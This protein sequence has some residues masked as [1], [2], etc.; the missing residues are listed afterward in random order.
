MTMKQRLVK[1]LFQRTDLGT[2]SGGCD[3]QS[4][5][6]FSKAQAAGDSFESA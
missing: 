4:L 2:H 5:G 3:V 6:A 1:P